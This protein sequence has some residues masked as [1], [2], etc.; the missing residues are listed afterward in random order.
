MTEAA[1]VG[2]TDQVAQPL[3]Y[4]ALVQLR[5]KLQ[6]DHDAWLRAEVEWYAS[7]LRRTWQ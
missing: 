7:W 6:R 5:D 3:T 1:A 2:K 4:E